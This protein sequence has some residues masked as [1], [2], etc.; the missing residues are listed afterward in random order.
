MNEEGQ[1]WYPALLYTLVIKPCRGKAGLSRA[2]D[3][4]VKWW[5][6][7]SY[8]AYIGRGGLEDML[9]ILT[10]LSGSL[11]EPAGYAIL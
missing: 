9:G 2:G 6:I 7:K 1:I 10:L 8:E 5:N 4:G 11:A 3:K